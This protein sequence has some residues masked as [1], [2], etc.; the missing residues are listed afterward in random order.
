MNVILGA[1]YLLRSCPQIIEPPS[2]R[3]A[4]ALKLLSGNR[5]EDKL[6]ALARPGLQS[7]DHMGRY[8]RGYPDLLE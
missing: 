3:R 4:G 2:D 6:S 5:S 1:S 8:R 7:Q